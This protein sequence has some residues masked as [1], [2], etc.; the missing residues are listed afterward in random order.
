M[1]EY[2]ED[3]CAG[4]Q[5]FDCCP[6]SNPPSLRKECC[7]GRAVVSYIFQPGDQILRTEHVI[8]CGAATLI[9]WNSSL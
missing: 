7:G 5:A 4:Q 8:A 6:E 2:L 1:K 9:C 3:Q